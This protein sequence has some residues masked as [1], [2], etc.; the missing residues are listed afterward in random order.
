VSPSERRWSG[1]AHRITL[2]EDPEPFA[3]DP[4]KHFRRTHK[5]SNNFTTLSPALRALWDLFP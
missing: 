3:T 5:V 1:P 2:P 4:F